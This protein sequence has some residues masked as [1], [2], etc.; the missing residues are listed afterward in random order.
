MYPHPQSFIPMARR[1]LHPRLAA[2]LTVLTVFA[3]VPVLA[4]LTVDYSILETDSAAYSTTDPNDPLTLAQPVFLAAQTGAISGTGSVIKTGAGTLFLSGANTYAGS[5]TISQGALAFKN[6][7]S[8]SNGDPAQ[9]TAARFTVETGAIAHFFSGGAGEFTTSDIATL[10][11][12]GTSMGGFKNG[13]TLGLDTTNATEAFIVNSDLA[14]LNGGANVL[15]LAK[16]G[17]GTLSLGGNNTFTGGVT[18]GENSVRT[19]FFP[20]FYT[21]PHTPSRLRLDS[22][23]ALGATG[24]VTFLGGAL[25]W[26]AGNAVDYSARFSLS[27]NQF[28]NLDTNG[29][30]IAFATALNNSSGELIKIGAGTL[31]LSGSNSLRFVRVFGG[32]LALTAG[33]SLEKSNGFIEVIDGSLQIP[34]GTVTASRT[35]IGSGGALAQMFA[36]DGAGAA[37]Q[38]TNAGRAAFATMDAGTWNAGLLM[39]GALNGAGSVG[40]STGVV[41]ING[42]VLNASLSLGGSSAFGSGDPLNHGTLNVNNGIVNTTSVTIGFGGSAVV[43]MSGGTWNHTGLEETFLVGPGSL[44]LSG[45]TLT[46]QEARVG[47][48]GTGTATISSSGV[49]TVTDLHIANDQ[50][51]A[52]GILQ[53]AGGQVQTTNLYGRPFV[54]DPGSSATIHLSSG[55]LSVTGNLSLGSGAIVNLTG[56]TLTTNDVLLSGDAIVNVSGGLWNSEGISLGHMFGG[57]ELNVSGGSVIASSVFVDAAS[58]LTMSAGAFECDLFTGANS[59]LSV[60][61]VTGGV[62]S[63]AAGRVP[64]LMT[65]NVSGGALNLGDG[66]SLEGKLNLSAGGAVT[67]GGGAGTLELTVNVSSLNLG[68]PVGQPAVAAGAFNAAVVTNSSEST[69]ANVNFN[70]IGDYTFASQITG[71]IAVIKDGPGTVTLTGANTYSGNTTVEAGTLIVNGTISGG[72][73]TVE[74]GATLGGIGSLAALNVEIGG[75]LAPGSS[76][77]TLSTGTFDL[78]SGAHLLLEL[79]GTDAGTYDQ[80]N[81]TGTVTLVG[82]LQISLL[83]GFTPTVGDKFFILLNDG[84][85]PVSGTFSN[86]DAFNRITIG[87]A[88]FLVNYADN[89][90]GPGFGND[91]SLT[92]VAVPEPGSAALLL[93][94][95]AVLASRRRELKI[96]SVKHC[97]PRILER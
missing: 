52:V 47:N 3:S 38:E 89:F 1:R 32:T 30:N 69:N 61:T 67:V 50:R 95:I 65:A 51:A 11:A 40:P 63:A 68:A 77:G 70:L 87:A 25:Q 73:T 76:P 16:I 35:A 88:E 71:R 18:L 57:T 84:I 8:L 5:T 54:S 7:I 44:N 23:G 33:G 21:G 58:M 9:W 29:Q 22:A 31:T 36:H 96:S 85:D 28:Y 56:G 42:G 26:S 4:Q 55:S 64:G 72:V 45:G 14:N 24:T 34:N 93:G 17:Y 2:W 15:S 82:D 37:Y 20:Q 13:S 46:A 92:V 53:I 86:D 90:S 27:E 75:N 6:R 74:N 80:L 81:V 59:G 94:A 79:G 78:Q 97:R 19:D 66:F 60:L 91:V 49:W 43:N 41:T 12:L 48:R 39:I 62:F 83:G 10:A